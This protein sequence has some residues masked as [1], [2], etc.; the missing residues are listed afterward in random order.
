[1]TQLP[2]FTGHDLVTAR[3][4]RTDPETS[5]IAAQQ[6]E[7]RGT[8]HI[9]RQIIAEVVAAHPGL[10][11]GEIPKYCDLD[12]FQVNKRLGEIERLGL[13]VRGEKRE[14]TVRTSQ[15]QTWWPKT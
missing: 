8:A 6:I 9:Q 5:H 13:I 3:A 4:R 1:M 2:L 15:Q 12:Y 14:C 7:E 10:T 11:A